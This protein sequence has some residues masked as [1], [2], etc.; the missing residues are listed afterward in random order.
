[1]ANQI[2]EW[3]NE[4]DKLYNLIIEIQSSDKNPNAQAE[5][6]F[7]KLCELYDI[8][9]TPEDTTIIGLNSENIYNPRSLFEEH[10][11]LKFLAPE[12]ED[13]RGIVLSAAHNILH[14]NLV[15]Y[16]EVAKKEYNNEIPDVCQIGVNGNEYNSKVI[17]F[18][19]ET[20]NW[21]DLGC[22]T[23][24]SVNKQSIIS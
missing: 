14:N 3:I 20:Q 19:K 10:A 17:F 18:Q 21:E 2:Q 1:M 7:N 13:P 12:N 23:I 16:Y 6:A 8:P 11:L 5:I 4:D 22:L 9:K 24:A 15:D